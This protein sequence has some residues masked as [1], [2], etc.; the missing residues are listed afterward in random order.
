MDS[1]H[2]IQTSIHQKASTVNLIFNS[3]DMAPATSCT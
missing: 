3:R 1:I 2:S